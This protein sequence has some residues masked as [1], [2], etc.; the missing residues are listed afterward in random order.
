V[1]KVTAEDLADARYVVW[2]RLGSSPIRR[3]M[4][5][6]DRCDAIV[7]VAMESMPDDV[8]MNVAGQ[9]T[10]FMDMLRD[11]TEQRV[12]ASYSEKC[13]FAFLTLIVTWAISE[14]VKQ[15]IIRWWNNRHPEVKP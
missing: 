4:L 3:A 8:E 7:R 9:D 2:K 14:I 5:G 15:L 12:L 10:E 1:K 6:R 13:G 11:R